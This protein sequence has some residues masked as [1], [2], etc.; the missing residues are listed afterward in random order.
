MD[1][2]KYNK[3]N[4]EENFMKRIILVLNV[5]VDGNKLK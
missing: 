1:T 5:E 3:W 2:C 4:G